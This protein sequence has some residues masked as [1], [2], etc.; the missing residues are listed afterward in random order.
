[1]RTLSA[2]SAIM[3][4]WQSSRAHCQKA[5]DREARGQL[6]RAPRLIRAT[7]ISF[8][9]PYICAERRLDKK[10]AGARVRV[11]EISSRRAPR[12]RET[13]RGGGG[14]GGG[15]GSSA[16]AAYRRLESRKVRE[17]VANRKY[18]TD[19]RH[20]RLFLGARARAARKKP[21]H[22]VRR[23]NARAHK[24]S[25][26]LT[27]TDAAAECAHKRAGLRSCLPSSRER[28]LRNAQSRLVGCCQQ[29]HLRAR[30]LNCAR[31]ISNRRMMFSG[32][33]LVTQV[34]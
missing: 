8:F 7:G 31:D 30:L 27:H 18:I 6:S 4:G 25:S 33:I 10:L 9:H 12:R 11:A 16:L 20:E 3:R 24:Q 26:A 22:A 14:G 19:K 17:L 34:Q 1:M 29:L 13:C 28:L 32:K 2:P 5:T 23:S 21:P 15:G